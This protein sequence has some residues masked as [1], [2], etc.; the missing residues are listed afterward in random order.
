MKRIIFII[1]VVIAILI[2]HNFASS[3]YNLWHKHDL[4]TAAK[5]DLEKEQKENRELKKKLTRVKSQEF[6]EEQ[7]RDKLFLVQPGEQ[8]VVI[9]E[10]LIPSQKPEKKEIIE[11]KPYWQQWV[12]LFFH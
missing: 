12:A 6:V 1:C 3:I 7:A 8:S 11:Q 9:P 5:R 10:N 2:I 4:L